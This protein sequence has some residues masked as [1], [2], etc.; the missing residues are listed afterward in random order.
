MM[1]S[2]GLRGKYVFFG[3]IFLQKLKLNELEFE[4]NL[5]NS[6]SMMLVNSVVHQT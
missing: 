3:E 2:D 6:V 5:T 1:N 4:M